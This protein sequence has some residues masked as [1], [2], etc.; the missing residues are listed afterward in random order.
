MCGARKTNNSDF[1][2][3]M[4]TVKELRKLLR[5][6]KPELVGVYKMRRKELCKN[7]LKVKKDWSFKK[8]QHRNHTGFIQ[9]DGRNSCYIDTTI[10][11]LLHARNTWVT[12]NLLHT[13]TPNKFTNP[14]LRD[15]ARQ[16]QAEL[17]LLADGIQNP[18]PIQT[19]KCS[20]LRS[21][22]KKFDKEY[23]GTIKTEWLNDQNEPRDVLDILARIMQIP[24]DV[25]LRR[26]IRTTI[27]EDV[28]FNSPI[29]G[30]EDLLEVDKPVHLHKYLPCAERSIDVDNTT[31]VQKEEILDANVLFVNI[32]RNYLDEKKL[33]TQVVPR[34]YMSVPQRAEPMR[35]V[36]ILVHIGSSPMSGHYVCVYKDQTDGVWY[37]YDD[38]VGYMRIGQWKNVLEYKNGF[39]KKNMVGLF[40]V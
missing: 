29:I 35:L 3:D 21:L 24:S 34:K 13:D 22:F 33:T 14:K 26:S 2:L 12:S 7:L 30:I 37:L 10:F 39:F 1:Y 11:A 15:I 9:Y 38:L 8:Q 36:S 28:M 23:N 27:T 20:K 32:V 4:L 18:A 25:K 40:Y 6:A 31:L 5:E 19:L 16:V 17:L